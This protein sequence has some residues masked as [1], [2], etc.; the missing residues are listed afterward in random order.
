[1]RC[2][3]KSTAGGSSHGGGGNWQLVSES[4]NS[5]KWAWR[6]SSS[7]I[8]A[9][10]ATPSH[11]LSP[12]SGTLARSSVSTGT[13]PGMPLE[14][15]SPSSLLDSS[16]LVSSDDPLDSPALV[17]AVVVSAVVVSA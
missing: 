2:P 7:A 1:M 5:S 9:L 10:F 4:Q 17:S 3:S 6:P 11:A 13:Q 14:L 15:D 8:T 12:D 16:V